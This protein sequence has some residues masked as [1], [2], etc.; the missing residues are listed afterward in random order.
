METILRRSFILIAILFFLGEVYSQSSLGHQKVDSLIA[1]ADTLGKN[2]EKLASIAKKILTLSSKEDYPKGKAYGNFT[3]ALSYYYSNQY[4]KSISFLDKALQEEIYLKSDPLFMA[5]A[6]CLYGNNYFLVDLNPLAK[7]HYL[8]ALHYAQKEDKDIA[9]KEREIRNAYIGMIAMYYYSGKIDSARHYTNVFKKTNFE[10][11]NRKLPYINVLSGNYHLDKSN[12]DSASYY[13]SKAYEK[14]KN[15]EEPYRILALHGLG[16]VEYRK[17]NYQK[18]REH[19][20]RILDNL[21]ITEVKVHLLKDLAELHNYLGNDEK[22]QEYLRR[23]SAIQDSIEYIKGGQ[24]SSILNKALKHTEDDAKQE[25]QR[26]SS[27]SGFLI[28]LLSVV[29]GSISFF[30]YRKHKSAQKNLF[31]KQQE[32]QSLKQKV[33]TELEEVVQLAKENDPSFLV[34][35]R[36]VKPEVYQM[37]IN[38]EPSLTKSELTLCAMIWLGFYTKD[39]ARYT[40]IQPKSVRMKKYRLRKKM[41]LPKGHDL[42][43]WVK[44]L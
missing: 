44:N 29:L 40:N 14:L 10:H 9:K 13:Y 33:N 30:F 7:Q 12:L 39:I 37:L 3:F 28:L 31:Q 11:E 8:I 41:E 35:F 15:T 32:T 24:R 20:T 18:A 38:L 42:Y 1:V 23:Y 34:R 27:I 21:R 19:F 5:D 22:E 4:Q 16:Q 43:D 2:P 25:T 6:H 17:G 36:E 26:L